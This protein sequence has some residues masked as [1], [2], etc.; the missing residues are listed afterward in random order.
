MVKY[1]RLYEVL[2][3][4]FPNAINGKD[5]LLEDNGEGTGPEIKYWNEQKLGKQIT[6]ETLV[7]L[8][9][10]FIEK[11]QNENIKIEQDLSIVQEYAKANSTEP[12]AALIRLLKY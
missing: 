12:L 1:P 6:E 3:V 2:C 4:N 5:F 10:E 9:R 8:H 7:Q 11:E